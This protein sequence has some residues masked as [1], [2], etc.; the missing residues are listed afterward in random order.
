MVTQ[1]QPAFC[2]CMYRNIVR[3][4]NGMNFNMKLR[5]GLV[6]ILAMVPLATS[7]RQVV[8][9]LRLSSEWHIAVDDQD[10][11]PTGE[12]GADS[13]PIAW[14]VPSSSINAST[15]YFV[16]AVS[17]GIHPMV[18]TNL[19]N[20]T[21][22]CGR[23][24]FNSTFTQ[25]P[26]TYA[27]Y[28]WLQS[29][30][31]LRNGTGW[32]LVHNEFK[33]EFYGNSAYCSCNDKYHN[34]S[35]C[36]NHCEMW[37]TGLAVTRDG[38]KHWELAAAPPRH[39]VASLPSKFTKDQRLAGYGAVSPMLRGEDGAYY[40]VI[41]IAGNQGNQSAGNCPFR[42]NSPTDPLSYRGWD[43]VNY[44]VQWH[45]AYSG[46]GQSGVCAVLETNY[47]TAFSEHVNFR[48]IAAPLAS[49]AGWPSFMVVGT[50][51]GFPPE[52]E[53]RYAFSYEKDF[54]K[55]VT[56]AWTDP[57]YIT[58]D[59][60]R[61]LDSHNHVLYPVIMDTS[62]P[63]LGAATASS[64]TD[65]DDLREDG[66]N[67]VLLGNGSANLFIV[68]TGVHA[69]NVLRRRVYF[70]LH[71]SP[72]PNPP[73]P[74]DP[75]VGPTI[76]LTCRTIRVRGAGISAFD[77]LYH[78]TTP[79]STRPGVRKNVFSDHLS[80]RRNLTGHENSF[81]LRLFYAKD[82]AHHLYQ[83]NGVAKFAHYGV[84]GSQVYTNMF[85]NTTGLPCGGW[86]LSGGLAPAPDVL[87]CEDNS[88]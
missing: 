19:E 86:R 57:R 81:G 73:Q 88:I 26:S 56:G 32:G 42:T 60:G 49:R 41:N 12:D 10:V 44:T 21:R 24:I 34:L 43:G 75:P 59:A 18:G 55:A 83:L 29:V 14:V 2:N 61:W 53:V 71:S 63:E 25:R 16:T 70:D 28:Q 62:S 1:I 6:I 80:P 65:T 82:S 50:G 78:K 22:Q 8:P 35:K 52:G 74:P 13:M 87:T 46:N 72:Q 47:N 68:T 51:R 76:P 66:D 17:K 58:L 85:Q 15:S 84:G 79:P 54:A 69:R 37:S 23:P 30:R 45:S 20:L 36:A 38:G 5:N 39:L 67:Y 33:A 40:G 9:S 3:M 31:V 77:G 48:R 11:C 64:S 7:Q 4:Q 27:N